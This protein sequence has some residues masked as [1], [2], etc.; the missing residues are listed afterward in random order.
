[1]KASIWYDVPY[2]QPCANPCKAPRDYQSES[3]RMRGEMKNI[4]NSIQV[5]SGSVN[6]FG[7][8]NLKKVPE[9]DYTNPACNITQSHSILLLLILILNT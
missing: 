5:S 8:Y 6:T 3:Q 1:M 7:V 9:T 4:R 2:I